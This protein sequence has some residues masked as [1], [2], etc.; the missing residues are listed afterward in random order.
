MNWNLNYQMKL[1]SKIQKGA[2]IGIGGGVN[3]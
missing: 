3:R 2:G 1:L